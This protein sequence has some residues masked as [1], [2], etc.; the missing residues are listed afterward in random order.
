MSVLD[1]VAAAITPP[2]SAEDRRNARQQ[3]RSLAT[4]GEWLSMVLDHHEQI[5]RCFEAVRAAQPADRPAAQKK[6]AVILTGHSIAEE[7]VLYPAMVEHDEKAGAAMAVTEQAAAK[8][9]MAM[10]EK[11]DPASQDYLDKLEHIRGAVA[12]HMYEEEGTWFARLKQSALQADQQMLTARFR[13]EFERYVGRDGENASG[14][15]T[16]KDATTDALT[17]GHYGANPSMVDTQT[18]MPTASQN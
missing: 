11:L 4:D 2:E 5:E 9:Q 18:T 12:H 1:K 8:T 6:L 13:E 17:A 16:G 14:I 10:L 7:S 15:A 3:A